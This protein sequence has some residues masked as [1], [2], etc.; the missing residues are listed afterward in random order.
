MLEEKVEPNVVSYSAGVSACEK[1]EQW[2]RA[3]VLLREMREATL[4]PDETSSLQVPGAR[5]RSG[6]GRPRPARGAP[7]AAPRRPL[8][9]PREVS[10]SAGI[11][12]CEKGEQ[13]QWSL[14]LLSEMWAAKLE[15]NVISYSA[16]ISACEKGRQWQRAL[17]LLSEIRQANLKPDASSPTAPGSARARK[18]D[19]GSGRCRCSARCGGRA[20][21]PTPAAATL[22]SWLA[23]EAG[24]ISGRSG[25]SRRRGMRSS[26]PTPSVSAMQS[27]M[28]CADECRVGQTKVLGSSRVGMAANRT[29]LQRDGQERRRSRNLI[30]DDA[31]A[32][33]SEI[34][35]NWQQVNYVAGQRE[36]G[37]RSLSR[38]I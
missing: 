19:N 12:A 33:A 20:W 24:R 7:G 11:S 38:Q 31:R 5:L 8:G 25:C 35:V 17:S 37:M 21:S 27:C 36:W 22:G 23:L 32:S 1:G 16:G 9:G 26:S 10:C 6:P 18:A 4:E 14:A 2:L 29:S 13:W 34:G 15:P 3:L 30:S 28:R